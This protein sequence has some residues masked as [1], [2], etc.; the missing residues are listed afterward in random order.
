MAILIIFFILLGVIGLAALFFLIKFLPFLI[1]L[2]LAFLAI[3]VIAGL[4]ISVIGVLAAFFGGIYCAL[5]KK[6]KLTGSPMK[7]EEAKEPEKRK[8]REYS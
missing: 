5:T 7:L 6:P 2:V 1:A 3:I 8:E 4:L